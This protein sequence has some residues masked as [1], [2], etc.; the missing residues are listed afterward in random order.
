MIQYLKVAFLMTSCFFVGLNCQN[1]YA[2]IP[3]RFDKEVK[4]VVIREYSADTHSKLYFDG[5]RKEATSLGFQLE[6]MDARND[7]KKMAKMLDTAVLKQADAI[8]ISHGSPDDLLKG[9]GMARRRKI[10][11]VAFDCEIPLSDV[12]KIDQD[13]HKMA[14]LGLN[15]IVQDTQ[16][17][18]KLVQIWVGGYAP[19]DKRME[20]FQSFM[21]KHPG[22]EE[23]ERFGKVTN[24]TA[25]Q[26]QVM[27]KSVL[28]K[29]PKGSIDVVWANWDEYARGAARAIQAAGRD[30]IK[31]YGIDIS[32]E[33]LEMIQDPDN[34]WIATVGVAPEAIGK[35]QV[36]IAA[37]LLAGAQVP[38]RYSLVPVLIT[39]EMLPTD[40]PVSMATLHQYVPGFGETTDFLPPWMLELKARHQ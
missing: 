10:P 2:E 3:A 13:D 9:I 22:I 28:Q 39:R 23:I 27:M 15:R 37:H 24:N 35:V 7:R 8:L 1:T 21:L 14:E 11:V 31:L 30:E 29:Y 33:D 17:K 32:D 4:L 18:A 5:V 19:A 38:E 40:Q 36:R 6:I 16:G 34:P 26:T 12:V 25:L 20:T